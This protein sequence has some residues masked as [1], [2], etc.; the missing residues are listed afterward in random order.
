MTTN[1]RDT[2]MNDFI[3]YMQDYLVKLEQ[4]IVEFTDDYAKAIDEDTANQFMEDIL[5]TS[6]EKNAVKHLLKKAE[7]VTK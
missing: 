7:E 1:E 3:K 4:E 6:G 2:N 5:M